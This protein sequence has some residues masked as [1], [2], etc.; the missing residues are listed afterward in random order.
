MFLVL[1]CKSP[2]EDLLARLLQ[3]WI[4]VKALAACLYCLARRE[5]TSEAAVIR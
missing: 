3:R 1:L 5:L 2:F 4:H